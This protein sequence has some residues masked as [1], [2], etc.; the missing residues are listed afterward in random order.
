MIY[1]LIAKLD[2][3]LNFPVV[4]AHCDIPCKIYDPITA[5][6][7]V[8]TLIRLIDL[9]DEL[10]SHKTLTLAQ[11]AEF[12]RLVAQKELHGVKVKEE[13]TIIWGDYIKAPQLEKFP[14][15]HELVHNIMLAASQA[16]Q[17][18]DKDKALVLLDLVNRFADIFWQ[19]KQVE[20]F[21]AVCPYPPSQK[22][23]Y[24]KLGES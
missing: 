9:I 3:K 21:T 8:L 5:Q 7:A 13:V 23:V 12:Q 24:P 17:H 19:T 10:K 22:I 4:S 1:Q 2:Q 18:L 14:E 16:K 11:Q 15:L 6:I 20:T